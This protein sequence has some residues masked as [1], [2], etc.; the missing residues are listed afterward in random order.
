MKHRLSDAEK[1]W[2]S[3][4]FTH[5]GR[6]WGAATVACVVV[7]YFLWQLGA[8]AVLG[9]MPYLIA[10]AGVGLFVVLVRR[11]MRPPMP[12]LNQTFVEV[13]PGGIW[14]TT[15][16]SRVL[17]LPSPQVQRVRVIR[18]KFNEIVRIVIESGE[19]STPVT[20]L[21]D[22]QVFLEDVL[23]TFERSTV[24]NDEEALEHA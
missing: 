15:P 3:R 4:P 16:N 23:S 2:R 10:A 5:T 1:A 6:F 12:V 9:F 22:M 14:R 8:G 11:L 18:S 21:N 17:V 7:P 24:D 13:T 20:G 19:A